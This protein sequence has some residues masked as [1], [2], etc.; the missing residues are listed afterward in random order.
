MLNVT[1]CMNVHDMG[2]EL[3]AKEQFSDVVVSIIQPFGIHVA[4]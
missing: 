2:C 4:R 3:A 1:Q